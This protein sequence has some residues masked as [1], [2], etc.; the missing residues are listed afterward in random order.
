MWRT[1]ENHQKDNMSSAPAPE[2][3]ML[4]VTGVGEQQAESP[5][6][7]KAGDKNALIFL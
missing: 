6:E 7:Q 3:S 2:P 5:S 4:W 1:C